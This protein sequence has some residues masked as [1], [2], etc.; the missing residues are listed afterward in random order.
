MLVPGL[1]DTYLIEDLCPGEYIIFVDDNICE[2]VIETII[3]AEP[4]PIEWTVTTEPLP[5]FGDVIVWSDDIL[6]DNGN[7]YVFE[8]G[9]GPADLYWYSSPQSCS[10]LDITAS[11]D[12]NNL[13]SGS[14]Y[15]YSVDANGCCT[16]QGQYTIPVTPPLESDFNIY[17][18]ELWIY[19]PGDNTG[20]IALNTYGGT[21]ADGPYTYL[22]EY[23]GDYISDYDNMNVV[24][25]LS[26]GEYQVTVNDE[27]ECGPIIHTVVIAE[28]DPIEF[29]IEDQ[30]DFNGYGISCNGNS[31]GFININTNTP[32]NYNYNWVTVDSNNNIIAQK[33]M[34][35]I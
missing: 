27:N 17:D 11:L 33:T 13:G 10:N 32:A 30:S 12:I 21:P 5:C 4:D 8:G 22:W 29:Y 28:S 20:V 18:S 31:D 24:E 16:N 19:C 23:N 7:D 1:N 35:L 6:I 2:P 26:I 14:Y 3:I 9:T 34:K 15:L 25:N